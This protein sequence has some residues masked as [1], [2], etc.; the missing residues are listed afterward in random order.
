MLRDPRAPWVH[1]VL[2]CVGL[3]WA[4]LCGDFVARQVLAESEKEDERY[5]Q[6][7][8]IDR[9]FLVPLWP[10]KVLGRRIVFP[11][12]NAW[13]KYQQVDVREGQK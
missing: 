9:K 3:S 2:G 1:Y 7:F 11:L 10:E 13:A 6:Y 5:C 12:N 8:S 4:T